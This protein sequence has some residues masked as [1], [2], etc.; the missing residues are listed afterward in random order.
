[1]TYPSLAEDGLELLQRRADVALQRTRDHHAD[2]PEQRGTA[3][4][5]VEG[6]R[7]AG[8]RWLDLA[9]QLDL[10]SALAVAVERH[11]LRRLPVHDRP[12]DA[13]EHALDLQDRR[14]L[15]AL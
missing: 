3:E 13:V 12:V 5:N 2:R 10:D 9:D 6:H 15:G 7:G 1:M 8:R 4:V 11:R 14:D